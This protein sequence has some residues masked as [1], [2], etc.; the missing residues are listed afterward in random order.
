ME[1]IHPNVPRIVAHSSQ[2]SYKL[3]L[4][5]FPKP[6]SLPMTNKPIVKGKSSVTYAAYIPESF[7]TEAKQALHPV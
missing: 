5:L 3:F 7:Y 4:C 6:V 2:I 1:G